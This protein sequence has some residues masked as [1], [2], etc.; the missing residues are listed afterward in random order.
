MFMRS[1]QSC[2]LNVFQLILHGS[3]SSVK[4]LF[5]LFLF[6]LLFWRYRDKLQLKS[7]DAWINNISDALVKLASVPK[8]LTGNLDI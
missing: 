5:L 2:C 4:N 7:R 1:M 8:Q 6:R 3:F